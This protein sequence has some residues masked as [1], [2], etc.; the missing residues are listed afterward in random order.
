LKT[1]VSGT[2]LDDFASWSNTTPEQIV[3]KPMIT[4][5]IPTVL[6]PNPLNKMAEVTIVAEVK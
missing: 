4:L 3:R 5:T 2:S 6:P 1:A